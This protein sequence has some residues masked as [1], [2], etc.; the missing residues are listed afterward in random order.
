M[1]IQRGMPMQIRGFMQS[2]I[3]SIEIR[4]TRDKFR[5]RSFSFIWSLLLSSSCS[6]L[7]SSRS[8]QAFVFL[9]F[10]SARCFCSAFSCCSVN[11]C[12]ITSRNSWIGHLRKVLVAT[13]TSFNSLLC[14]SSALASNVMLASQKINKIY[15]CIV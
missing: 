4:K 15:L 1:G 7:T 5:H 2:D 10:V 14:K 12:N 3:E 11:Q 6:T 9:Y 13:F 8:H